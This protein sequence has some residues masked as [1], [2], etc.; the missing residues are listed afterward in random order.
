MNRHISSRDYELMVKFVVFHTTS[1]SSNLANRK[2]I[3][4][5][6]TIRSTPRCVFL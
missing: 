4:A 2:G 6:L 1:A 3:P 5:Y